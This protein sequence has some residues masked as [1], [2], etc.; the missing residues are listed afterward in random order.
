MCGVSGFAYNF[1]IYSGQ[2]NNPNQRL[3]SK[4]DLGACAN[5]VR[6][7][8]IMPRNSNYILYFVN[9]YTTIDLLSNFGRQ[10]P[11]T[12]I[13]RFD[14]PTKSTKEINCPFIIKEYNKHMGGVDL[15]DANIARHKIQIKSRKW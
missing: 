1:E 5:V 6:L 3:S 2:E 7:S 12:T 15:M 13:K 4:P 10:T 14:R 8:R 9:Y 11:V